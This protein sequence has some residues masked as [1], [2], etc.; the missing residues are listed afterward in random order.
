MT[1]KEFETGHAKIKLF[2]C[3]SIKKPFHKAETKV[4]DTKEKAF[5]YLSIISR[6]N[7]KRKFNKISANVKIEFT[8]LPLLDKWEVVKWEINGKEKPND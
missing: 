4:F 7:Y 6:K 1:E 5:D 2:Y 3:I 8:L